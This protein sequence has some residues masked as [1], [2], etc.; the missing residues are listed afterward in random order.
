MSDPRDCSCKLNIDPYI[1]L[2]EALT[3]SSV[4]TANTQLA[5]LTPFQPSFT[6][7]SAFLPS[8]PSLPFLSFIP[9]FTSPSPRPPFFWLFLFAPDPSPP[10]PPPPPPPPKSYSVSM[11]QHL[12]PGGQDTTVP[13]YCDEQDRER[14][15][16]REEGTERGREGGKSRKE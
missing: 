9:P 1:V 3:R 7:L 12:L 2:L 14:E 6:P 5:L 16:A 4:R 13:S 10:L 8:L 15:G 11:I